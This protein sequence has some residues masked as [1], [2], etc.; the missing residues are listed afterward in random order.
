MKRLLR[1]RLTL[2]R[3]D[4]MQDQ[5]S[6]YEEALAQVRGLNQDQSRES[7]LIPRQDGRGNGLVEL[8]YRSWDG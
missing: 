2:P 5:R 6:Q 3:P 4:A 7:M 1:T 8:F